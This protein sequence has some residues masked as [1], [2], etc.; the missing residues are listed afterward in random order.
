[1]NSTV[2]A[3]PTR[4]GPKRVFDGTSTQIVA[5]IINKWRVKIVQKEL[6]NV[7]T[8]HE[9]EI[10]KLRNEHCSNQELNL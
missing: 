8:L 1:M 5:W 2:L 7:E 10:E 6:Y 3:A 9:E 4:K